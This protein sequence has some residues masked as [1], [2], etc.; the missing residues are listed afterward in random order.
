MSTL[1]GHIING[2]FDGVVRTGDEVYY[3]ELAKKFKRDT[4]GYHSVIYRFKDVLL[5]TTGSSCG[6]KD[7]IYEQMKKAQASAKPLKAEVPR[8][9]ATDTLSD[10]FS[11]RRG[12]STSGTVS[13]GKYCQMLVAVDDLFVQHIGNGNT[14]DT[15]NEIASIF[16]DVQTTYSNAD[17]FMTGQGSG[18]VPT[19]MKIQIISPTNPT[20]SGLS[21]TGLAVTDFL[22]LWSSYNHDNYCLAMLLTY[23]TFTGGVLGLAWVANPPGGNAGG[24]CQTSVTLSARVMSLNTAIVTFQNYGAT[25][26]RPVSV[27]T[28]T[29]E[30]GH[31]FGSPVSVVK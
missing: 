13:G 17:F 22:N 7:D 26:A 1:S 4:P 24:I 15:V 8:P 31:S 16:A 12:R 27:I 6:L 28:V 5:N 18:V 21:N 23:H 10:M 25:V 2:V 19:I 14:V 30:I 11:S 3:V 20:Y 9:K 29:H